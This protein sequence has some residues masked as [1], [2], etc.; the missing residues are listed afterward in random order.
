V[1]VLLPTTAYV[2]RLEPPPA[3]NMIDSGVAIALG[4]D[5][6][7]NAPCL[8]MPLVM[9]MACV[10]LGLTLNEALVAATLNAAAS[11]GRGETHGALQPGRVADMVML[12][13]AKWEHI[14]Y[15]LGG[16]RDVITHVF[17]NGRAVKS[18]PPP[19]ETEEKKPPPQ[20][21]L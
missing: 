4:S 8:S 21:R 2:L 1:G 7:P 20:R 19:E 10:N 17:K 5:F 3:R 9:H 16:E 6:N 13:A 18:P 15:M 11:I 14:I 12:D